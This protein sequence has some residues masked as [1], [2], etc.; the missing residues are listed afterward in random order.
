ML[1]VRNSLVSAWDLCGLEGLGSFGLGYGRLL[2]V[3][4]FAACLLVVVS[5]GSVSQSMGAFRFTAAAMN[6][7]AA[8]WIGS[9]DVPFPG[10]NLQGN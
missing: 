1:E 4:Q 2:G 6:F 7:L 3:G 9:I 5:A 8:S 10:Y